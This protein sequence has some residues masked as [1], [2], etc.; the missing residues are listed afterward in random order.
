MAEEERER[1]LAEGVRA[2]AAER[3]AGVPRSRPGRSRDAASDV[4]RLG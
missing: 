4:P 1:R 3:P 2:V